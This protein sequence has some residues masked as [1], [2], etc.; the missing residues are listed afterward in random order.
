[1]L[2]VRFREIKINDGQELA[3]NEEELQLLLITITLVELQNEL[4]TITEVNKKIKNSWI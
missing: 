1:M 4:I 2:K 3:N